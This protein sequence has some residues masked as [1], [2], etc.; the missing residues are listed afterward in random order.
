MYQSDFRSQFKKDY[1]R[2]LK[3]GLPEKEIHQVM[4]Q[5]IEGKELAEKYRL[6][7]LVGNYK[8]CFECH[9]RPDW[10]LIFLK[11]DVNMLVE[12]VRTGSHSDL[13]G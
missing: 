8:D 4:R 1:K 10:L 13:F 2:C 5:I 11:D 6:H 3:R 9:I 7:R 12:F